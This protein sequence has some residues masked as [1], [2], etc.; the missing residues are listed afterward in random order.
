M[1]QPL[2]NTVGNWLEVKE[3]ID[4][5]HGNGPD[6]LMEV[7]HQLCGAMI[8]LG[9]KAESIEQGV[10]ISQKMISSGKAWDKFLLSSLLNGPGKKIPSTLFGPKASTAKQA[11]TAESI[12]PLIPK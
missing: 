9:K 1:N 10:E 3:C 8:W 6:D 4:C 2:G 11:T 12:P 5:L 7:T